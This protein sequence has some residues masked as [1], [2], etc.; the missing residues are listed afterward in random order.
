MLRSQTDALLRAIGS[1]NFK[2]VR[3]HYTPGAEVNLD[4]ELRTYLGASIR[5]V[6]LYQ[7]RAKAIAVEL[8]D[9][10]L[11]AKTGVEVLLQDGRGRIYRKGII[12]SWARIDDG[13]MSFR[14]VPQTTAPH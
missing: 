3:Q 1:G 8:S 10:E 4:R 7:W 9:D 14:L 2:K 12:F 11:Q 5:N 6:S 13:D